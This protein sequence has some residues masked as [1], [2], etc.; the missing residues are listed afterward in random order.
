MCGIAGIISKKHDPSI[1]RNLSNMTSIIDYRGPDAEG[2]KIY[3]I[4]NKN[5]SSVA[6]GHRR[7][8]I[9]DLTTDSNQPYELDGKN[10]SIVFNGEIYNHNELREDLRKKGYEFFTTSDTE[11]LLNSYIEWGSNCLGKLNGMFSFAIFDKIKSEVFCARDRLGI[12]PF[13]Y[14]FDIDRFIFSSEIKQILTTDWIKPIPNIKSINEY[15]MFDYTL[16]K[17]TWFEGISKLEPGYYLTFSLVTFEYEVSRYWSPISRSDDK[18]DC[19]KATQNLE[20]LI[21]D[22]L[23][24]QVNA[25]VEV[26]AHLSGGLDSSLVS[27]VI[28]KFK[29]LKTFTGKFNEGAEYDETMWAKRVSK[30]IQSDYIE[31]CPSGIDFWKELKEIVWHLDEP[32]VGPGVYP[33]FMVAREVKK[34]VT[35]VLGGQGGDELFGGYNR[36][37]AFLA[38]DIYKKSNKKIKL[39]T[40]N[41]NIIKPLLKY[42]LKRVPVYK[43]LSYLNANNLNPFKTGEWTFDD[44]LLWDITNYLQALLQVEDRTSMANSIESRVPLLDH[45]IVEFAIGLPPEFKMNFSESKILLREI[46]KK[47]IPKDVVERRDKK[48]FP[49]PTAVWMNS[50]EGKKYLSEKLANPNSFVRNFYSLKR[51]KKALKNPIKNSNVLWKMINIELWN[52]IFVKS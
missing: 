47:Y 40:S 22:S 49:T 11:V 10:Y 50:D 7:L 36:Y 37:L 45:R 43:Y 51:I 18:I 14:Y 4:E 42:K 33:Q 8:S 31:I 32:I 23:R 52:E 44:I 13:Y 25:D 29:P 2:K 28:S 16:G 38:N 12:K 5:E 9:L 3:N 35:V 6:L 19:E 30:C 27:A 48:G 41:L 26:G 15:V 20:N 46:A 39:L 17:K 1:M 34:H 24:M 21:V